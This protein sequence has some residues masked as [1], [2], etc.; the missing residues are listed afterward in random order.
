MDVHRDTEAGKAVLR[1]KRVVIPF[2]NEE[3]VCTWDNPPAADGAESQPSWAFNS[4]AARQWT[5]H[6]LPLQTSAAIRRLFGACEGTRAGPGTKI[7][8]FA[9]LE[10][11]VTYVTTWRAA[12]STAPPSWKDA[13]ITCFIAYCGAALLCD[14]SPVKRATPNGVWRDLQTTW[15]SW[16]STPWR[17]A[18]ITPDAAVLAYAQRIWP[19]LQIG[20]SPR[21]CKI[22]GSGKCEWRWQQAMSSGEGEDGEGT[23]PFTSIVTVTG[24]DTDTDTTPSSALTGWWD[25]RLTALWFS[26]PFQAAPQEISRP[27]NSRRVVLHRGRIWFTDLQVLRDAIVTETERAF[28]HIYRNDEVFGGPGSAPTSDIDTIPHSWMSLLRWSPMGDTLADQLRFWVHGVAW[29]HLRCL[30]KPVHDASKKRLIHSRTATFEASNTLPDIEDLGKLTKKLKCASSACACHHADG[31]S[32]RVPGAMYAIPACMRVL[33]LRVMGLPGAIGGHLRHAERMVYVRMLERLGY[34]ATAIQCHMT[35]QAGISVAQE[36]ELRLLVASFTSS[37]RALTG[38]GKLR[39]AGLCP[40][41]TEL[42][43]TMVTAADGI[44]RPVT[45]HGIGWACGATVRRVINHPIAYVEA[46]I[47]LLHPPSR[48][49]LASARR[50]AAQASATAQG[51][52]SARRDEDESKPRS[53]RRMRDVSGYGNI[54]A[55]GSSGSSVMARRVR[56]R[57]R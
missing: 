32:T 13:D 15:T 26:L 31:E 34:T 14:T 38:C 16:W 56:A 21:V 36:R 33:W 41:A 55:V 40:V 29:A 52:K 28:N 49:I 3:C 48:R 23:R 8:N 9:T 17:N 43:R 6:A 2:T 47:A 4:E 30:L 24:S 10:D 19:T 12:T 53:K 11:F 27:V 44:G 46:A 22:D 39:K 18:D 1:G 42:T 35:A 20:P 5:L 37:P 25:S 7:Y 50:T 57:Y 45:S 54:I 51:G